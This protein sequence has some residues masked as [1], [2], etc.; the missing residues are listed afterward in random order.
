MSFLENELYLV[1]RV[2]WWLGRPPAQRRLGTGVPA[3]SQA[4]HLEVGL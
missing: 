2:G 1:W 3:G 4:P